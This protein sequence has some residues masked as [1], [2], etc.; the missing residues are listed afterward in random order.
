MRLS[1]DKV[2]RR[3]DL[4]V[5]RQEGGEEEPKGPEGGPIRWKRQSFV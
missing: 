4:R 5:R 2:L 1:G 3:E